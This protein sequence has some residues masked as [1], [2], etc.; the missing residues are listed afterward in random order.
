MAAFLIIA[1]IILVLICIVV[2]I[3]STSALRLV[4]PDVVGFEIDG[5]QWDAIA[6]GRRNRRVA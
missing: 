5:Q 2:F 1:L 4:D 3:I 6:Q